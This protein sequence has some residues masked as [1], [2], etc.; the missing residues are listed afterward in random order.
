MQKNALLIIGESKPS[1]G[2]LEGALPGIPVTIEVEP[3][4]VQV[5]E[6][7]GERNGWKQLMLYSGDQRY[8]SITVRWKAR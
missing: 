3:S 6:A 1:F 2:T 4:S 5:R 8:S 7:P